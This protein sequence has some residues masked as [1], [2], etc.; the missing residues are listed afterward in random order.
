MTTPM[1][2]ELEAAIERNHDVVEAFM[3]GDP[4]AFA[5]FYSQ[6]PD[7]TLGNP[8]GPFVQ[9]FDRVVETITRAAR[10]YRDGEVLG[11][12]LIATHATPAL[13]VTVEV[14]RLEGKV[15]AR[16]G[17]T[18]ITLRCTSVFRR[19]DGIGRLVHRHA[20]PITTARPAESVIEG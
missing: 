19:E 9:G 1:P 11:F 15:G 3:H 7:V 16:E 14:E 20:D 18:P 8:F 6:R 13:A 12:E 5:E 4:G 17:V 2:G 10:N